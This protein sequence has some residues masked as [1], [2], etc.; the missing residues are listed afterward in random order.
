MNELQSQTDKL[1]VQMAAMMTTAPLMGLQTPPQ[2]QL[3]QYQAPPQMAF[4]R[5]QVPPTINVPQQQ[6]FQ[7]PISRKK[8]KAQSDGASQPNQWA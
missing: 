3:P 8:R 6:L 4:F 7:Q 2:W 5:Q 1:R